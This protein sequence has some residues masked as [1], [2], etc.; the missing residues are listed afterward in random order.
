MQYKNVSQNMQPLANK[1][2]EKTSRSWLFFEQMRQMFFEIG[3]K[4]FA[5]FTGKHLCWGLFLIN[6]QAFK[7][8]PLFKTE[9]V[10]RRCF[11]K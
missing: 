3:V 10:V 6:V 2:M 7:P 9:A 4:N 8:A 11:A 5:N 1:S